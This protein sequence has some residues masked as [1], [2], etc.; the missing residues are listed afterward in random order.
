MADAILADVEASGIY[1]IRNLES[2]KKY[3]G[4]AKCFRI[5]WNAH[6]A[7]L[8]RGSHHSRHLQASWHK[9]GG[10]AFVFEVVEV[11]SVEDLLQREQCWL[12]AE[13]PEYNVCPNAGNTLGRRFTPESREKIAAKARGRTCPPRSAEHRAKLSAVHAGKKKPQHVM[14]ALQEGR[15][16][17]V[18]TDEQREQMSRSLRKAY[19]EGRKPREKS[20][21]HR[22]S[23]GRHFAKLSDNEIRAIRA[24]RASGVTGRELARRYGSNPGTISEI[25]SG[26]RYRWVT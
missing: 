17:R 8:N 18:F 25:C 21:P 15:R 11:C 16:R 1:Q 19:D 6:R 14:R 10:D 24:L 5:R 4:S 13:R 12:D 2:G 20:E 22:F 9:N 7:K 23:I 26:K 3:I